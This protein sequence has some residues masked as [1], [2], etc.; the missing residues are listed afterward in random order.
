V[1]RLRFT[2]KPTFAQPFSRVRGPFRRG[3]RRGARTLARIELVLEELLVNHVLMPTAP[4]KESPKWPVF[5]GHRVIFCLEVVDEA[6]PFDPLGTRGTRPHA[7]SGGSAHSAAWEFTWFAR[8][9][10][11]SATVA[12]RARMWSPSVSPGARGR[13]GLNGERGK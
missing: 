4:A 10:T 3:G 9:P 7:R 2:G 8:W 11:K 6:D 12:K 5:A 13:A 1:E